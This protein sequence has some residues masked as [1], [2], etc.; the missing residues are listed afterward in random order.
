MSET[1]NLHNASEAGRSH[2]LHELAT[3]LYALL[4]SGHRELAYNV[5]TARAALSGI[6]REGK[7]YEVR[8]EGEGV[9]GP[10]WQRAKEVV[11]H[12]ERDG[13]GKRYRHVERDR[14][15]NAWIL[16]QHLRGNY[17]VAPAAPG[18]VEWVALDIDAHPQPGAPELVARRLA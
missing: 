18:W 1:Q 17:S 3:Q 2:E 7:R 5:D 9:D 10:P 6:D 8:R 11:T 15:C 12:V 16:E 4:S 13:E 14:R